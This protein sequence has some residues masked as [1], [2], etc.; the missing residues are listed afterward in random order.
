MSVP[1]ISTTDLA[2]H[3]GSTVALDGLTLD[4]AAGEIFGFLGPNG[5]GKTTTIR[6]L[7]GLARP[8]RGDATI[9]GV[10]VRD[11]VRAHRHLGYV[12]GD[13][14]LWPQLTGRE[15]LTLLGN[16]A[17]GVDAAYRDAL[18]ERLDL[19]PSRR[20]RTYSKG[21]RQKVALIAAF[22]TRPSVLL[23]DEPTAG[24]DPLME[25]QF[26]QLAREAAHNG[27]TV[28]LSSHILDEVQDLC[29][30]VGFL[31]SG[32]L[33]EVATVA[34]LR[35]KGT[36]ILELV[37]D[38]TVPDLTLVP[39]ITHVEHLPGVQGGVRVTV[40]GSVQPLL[41]SL[42]HVDVERMRTIEPSLEDVFLSYY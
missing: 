15:T 26:Q 23:F 2:K 10:T 17:G 11:V 30:R 27:Q 1:A 5:S 3:Y 6:L 28:F 7:L 39:G 19:D 14:A 13:V 31:R 32:R 29:D 8:T 18:C 4:V 16:V 21:N 37:I 41:A 24:L 20:V 38:G 22:M 36:T 12:A 40:S 25:Q 9:M 33:V 34:E 42:A 35:H